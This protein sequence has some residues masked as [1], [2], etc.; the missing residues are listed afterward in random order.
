M[1][2]ERASGAAKSHNAKKRMFPSSP[3]LG[4]GVTLMFAKRV[5]PSLDVQAKGV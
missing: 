2:A 5:I 4:Y 1:G 3:T